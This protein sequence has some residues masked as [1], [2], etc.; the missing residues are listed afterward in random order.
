MVEEHEKKE[1]EKKKSILLPLIVIIAIAAIILFFVY[2]DKIIIEKNETFIENET[3]EEIP[4]ENV[5]YITDKGFKPILIVI[6]KGE[7]V[8][9]INNGTSEHWP[10]SNLHPTH[11]IYP[12]S[13]LEKCGTAEESSI[14]DACKGLKEG[15]MYSFTFD[16]SGSWKYHDHLSIGYFGTVSVRS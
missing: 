8:T 15:E 13:G 7:T 3:E 4:L 1:N 16:R 12:G 11:K 2:K 14:F 10:A 9:W 6:K 5:V